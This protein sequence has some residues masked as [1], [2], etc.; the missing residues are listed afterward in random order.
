[1]ESVIKESSEDCKEAIEDFISQQISLL[2]TLIWEEVH[3]VINFVTACM[4]Y[5]KVGI[6]FAN[7]VFSTLEELSSHR[8]WQIR[9]FFENPEK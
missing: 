4:T 5:G 1:M 2:P 9:K 3:I 8:T 7:N 6:P